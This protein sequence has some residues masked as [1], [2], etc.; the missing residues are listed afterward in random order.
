MNDFYFSTK[1]DYLQLGWRSSILFTPL[2][3][4]MVAADIHV[5]DTGR[6]AKRR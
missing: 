1:Q 3:D 5:V 4:E 2:A 6:E